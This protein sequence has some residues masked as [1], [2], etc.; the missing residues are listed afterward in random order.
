[1]R[2]TNEHTH[3]ELV[4]AEFKEQQATKRR[5]DYKIIKGYL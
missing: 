2:R 5:K 1:M 4:C 3:A